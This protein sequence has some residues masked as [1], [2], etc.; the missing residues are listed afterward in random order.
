[1]KERNEIWKII[2]FSVEAEKDAKERIRES[3]TRLTKFAT[4]R[5]DSFD[6]SVLVAKMIEL[7]EH[8]ST[9][10]YSLF[11]KVFCGDTDLRTV[12]GMESMASFLG[13]FID[14]AEYKLV[15]EP[16]QY[17]SQCPMLTYEI[18]FANDDDE[19]IFIPELIKI[20]D[21]V[22]EDCERWDLQV[23]RFSD[24]VKKD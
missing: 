13:N 10:F 5:E 1:M 18:Q 23:K 20:I 6:T 19:K 3:L 17:G 2:G 11:H 8:N 4:P 24:R 9:S 7:F 14:D 21:E 12:E 15:N 16:N 22:I